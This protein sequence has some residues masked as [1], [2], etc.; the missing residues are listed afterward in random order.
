MSGRY[1]SRCWRTANEEAIRDRDRCVLGNVRMRT[2][3]P[4]RSASRTNTNRSSRGG[5]PPVTVPVV[6]SALLL[7]DVINDLAF[8]GSAVLIAQA[9]PMAHRLAALKCRATAAGLPVIYVNDNFGRWRS[10]F[11]RT[12][13][14]CTARSS[15]GRRV[16]Q[17]PGERV[18]NSDSAS[19]PS[20]TLC[21]AAHWK[22]VE[23]QDRSSA[24]IAIL[25]RHRHA[26]RRSRKERRDAHPFGLPSRFE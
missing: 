12:V 23:N 9:E 16:S 8:K 5:E 18:R 22:P 24:E 26:P 4:T 21:S 19:R 6:G 11:R 7:I 25:S 15:P 10:D 17:R 20:S 13:A 14:H 3:A 2:A 1:R